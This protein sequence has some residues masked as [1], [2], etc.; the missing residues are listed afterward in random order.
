[1]NKE[2]YY[3]LILFYV[4][5]SMS[6]KSDKVKSDMER[7]SSDEELENTSSVSITKTESLPG[8][9]LVSEEICVTKQDEILASE[10]TSEKR[11]VKYFAVECY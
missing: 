10:K 6:D 8:E 2:N 1:M 5:R 7:V 4:I 3:L 9:H 11:F